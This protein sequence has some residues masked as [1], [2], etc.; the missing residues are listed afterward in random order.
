[1]HQS[2]VSLTR[3]GLW[4]WSRRE[5]IR[6][7]STPLERSERTPSSAEDD[8]S[9]AQDA[10]EPGLSD[11]SRALAVEP[12]GVEPV[13]AKRI[14]LDLSYFRDTAYRQRRDA[15]VTPLQLQQ[16]LRIDGPWGLTSVT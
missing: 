1:M 7:A 16:C 4:Q 14:R 6:S 8:D 10:S 2:P 5:S 15:T 11:E 3:A 9:S 13:A 12:A